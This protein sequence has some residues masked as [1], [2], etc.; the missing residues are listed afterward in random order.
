[1]GKVADI[2]KA[3]GELDEALRIPK[4]EELPV[5]EKLGDVRASAVTI[6]KIEA[7]RDKK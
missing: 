4:Q 6:G 2:L 1:M 7:M 3:R 5:Y